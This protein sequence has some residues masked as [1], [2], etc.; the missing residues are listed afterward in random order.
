M[1][2]SLP[3]DTEQLP[4]DTEQLPMDTSEEQVQRLSLSLVNV[5]FYSI[6]LSQ[7]ILS[8]LCLN[9]FYLFVSRTTRLIGSIVSLTPLESFKWVLCLSPGLYKGCFSNPIPAYPICFLRRSSKTRV[10]SFCLILP[11]PLSFL[12]WVPQ[13]LLD[14]SFFVPQLRKAYVI[15]LDPYVHFTNLLSC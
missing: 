11:W 8:A 14:S 5:R 10:N 13:S 2:P 1:L 7:S 6:S 4:M 12:R 9:L 15:F 3:M